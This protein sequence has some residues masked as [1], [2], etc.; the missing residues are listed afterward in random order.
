[1]LV[2]ISISD[3]VL[4]VTHSKISIRQ[5]FFQIACPS[6]VLLLQIFSEPQV[7]LIHYVGKSIP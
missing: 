1:L 2:C 3:D 4:G 7:S 5:P 6:V